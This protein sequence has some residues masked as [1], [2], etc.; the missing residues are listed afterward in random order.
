MVHYVI[1]LSVYVVLASIARLAGSSQ[2]AVDGDVI[3]FPILGFYRVLA[4]SAGAFCALAAV[5]DIHSEGLGAFGLA[6]AT[7]SLLTVLLPLQSVSISPTGIEALP[8]LFLRRVTIKWETVSA[9]EDH[10]SLGM[11]VIRSSKR[12]ITFT[13]FNGDRESFKCLLKQRTRLDLWTS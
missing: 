6:F 3:V 8:V 12:S 9:I 1:V 13:R 7:I 2:A 4:W 5:Y 11:V 10:P